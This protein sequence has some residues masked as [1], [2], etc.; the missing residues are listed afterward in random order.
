MWFIFKKK[1]KRL[2]EHPFWKDDSNKPINII[3]D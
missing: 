3:S 2:E 1:E